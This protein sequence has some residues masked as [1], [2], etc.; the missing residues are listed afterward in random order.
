[1]LP[2][3][4]AR[5]RVERD[6]DLAGGV[7][8]HRVEPAPLDGGRRMPLAQRAGPQLHGPGGR[9]VRQQTRGRRNEI[10]VGASPDRPVRARFRG[11]RLLRARGGRGQHAQQR[12][13]MGETECWAHDFALDTAIE[14]LV[15][16]DQ[17]ESRRVRLPARRPG[18]TR[19]RFDALDVVRGIAVLG[20]LLMNIEEMGTPKAAW[21]FPPLISWTG[22]DQAV[23]WL[24]DVLAKGTMRGLLSLL[25]GAGFIL[26]T[27]RAGR[28]DGR[29]A[30]AYHRR[31]I[32]LVIFGIVHGYLLLW[33]GDILLIYGAIGLFLFPWRHWTPTRLLKAGATV[34]LVMTLISAVHT[35]RCTA[36]Q[37]GRSGA[38]PAT[39]GRDAVEHRPERDDPMGA[40]RQQVAAQG[41]GDQEGHAGTAWWVRRQLAVG[42]RLG[43]ELNAPPSFF[44]WMLDALALMFVGAA[45]V[46]WGVIQGDRAPGFYLMLAATGYVV[47]ISLNVAEAWPVWT[48]QFK[49][50]IVW[51]PLTHQVSR[52]AVTFGHLGLILLVFGTSVGRR[53]LHPFA[54]VGRLALSNYIAQTLICQWLLFPGFGLGLF[55]RFGLAR[56]WLIALGIHVVQIVASVLY[57]RRYQMGPLEWVLR[58]LAY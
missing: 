46:K 5:D 14:D 40:A 23:W 4:L 16:G 2:Q 13:D 33:P 31:N 37:A 39:D 42:V 56:L 51:S 45:L 41:R 49:A 18:P 55:G 1:M 7:A 44:Y 8:V 24:R 9:P 43:H 19:I 54:A 58:R 50:P 35:P 17:V 6:D 12:D 26:M 3:R 36:V 34:V 25:F 22:A 29:V 57:L 53:V 11:W 28:D 30:D 10:A 27:T 52:I 47:G 32:W 38:S 48:S 20:I 21:D 15:V